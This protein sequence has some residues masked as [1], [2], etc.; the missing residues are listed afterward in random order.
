VVTATSGSDTAY[1]DEIGETDDGL[2]EAWRRQA[3]LEHL[4]M[5]GRW[6]PDLQG[7]WLK[8]DLFEERTAARSLLPALRGPDWIGMDLAPV[9]VRRA[10]AALAA[11]GVALDAVASDVC[12]LPLRDGSVDGVLSTSTL[13]H[14]D[15]VETIDVA[16]RELRRVTR[17]GGVLV[18][19]LDNPRNPLIALRNALPHDV[20]RR[21]G[22]APFAVGPTLAAGPAADAVTR[23]GWR[24]DAVEHLLHVPHIVGTRLARVDAYARHVLPR[25]KRLANTRVGPYSGHFVAVLARAT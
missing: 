21:T 23:C 2:P 7:R 11:D 10:R 16:L 8:T 9:V 5:L 24:V 13:D 1:W 3:R 17:R 4:A 14:F 12:S 22:L 6:V 18:L 15:R 25:W 19:T 20:A